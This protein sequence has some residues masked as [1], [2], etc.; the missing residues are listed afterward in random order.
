MFFR[1]TQKSSAYFSVLTR[2]SVF[3]TH[4]ILNRLRFSIVY[5]QLAY[6]HKKSPYRG[7]YPLAGEI[8]SLY[9]EKNPPYGEKIP[10]AGESQRSA[11][12]ATPANSAAPLRKK[13]GLGGEASSGGTSRAAGAKRCLS[14]A[15]FVSTADPAVP[16]QP[17]RRSLDFFFLFRSSFVSRQKKK[18]SHTQKK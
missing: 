1:G 15:S 5:P 6:G 14:E 12:Q 10:L 2:Y 4:S 13:N 17:R 11:R 8:Y 7:F 18:K 3:N 9:R 16:Q